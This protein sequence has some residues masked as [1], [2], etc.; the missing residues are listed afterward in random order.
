MSLYHFQFFVSLATI[1]LSLLVYTTFFPS[2]PRYIH[3]ST[4]FFIAGLP[5][6]VPIVGLIPKGLPSPVTTGL[7]DGS[8]W[9]TYKTGII[10]ITLVGHIEAIAIGRNLAIK[11]H[12]E[13]RHSHGIYLSNCF[14][15]SIKDRRREKGV[16]DF[17]SQICVCMV[18]Q[19]IQP[20]LMF[21]KLIGHNCA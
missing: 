7:T 4:S 11:N 13:L 18:V 1:A 14:E 12:Y 5:T 19:L 16:A 3:I 10:T 20:F 15:E 21:P 2:I 8:L 6:G 17:F 9:S